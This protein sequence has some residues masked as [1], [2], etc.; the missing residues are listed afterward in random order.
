MEKVVD[1]VSG[2]VD[3]SPDPSPEPS[4]ATESKVSSNIRMLGEKYVWED[5]DLITK[6]TINFMTFN[7]A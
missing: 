6:N 1:K 3:E 2:V 5:E 7:L 4:V